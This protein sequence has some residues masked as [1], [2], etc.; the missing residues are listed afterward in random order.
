[1]SEKV[2]ERVKALLGSG[3]IKGFLGLSNT[4]GHVGPHLFSDPNDLDGMVVG[5]WRLPGDTRY[6][7]NKQLIHIA[8]RYPDDA[9]GV[10][11]RGCDDRGLKTLYTWNQLNPE[12]VVPVGVACPQELAE[13]CECLRPYPEEFV[14]GEKVEGCPFDSVARVNALDMNGRFGY[15]VKEFSRCI[16]CYGC[17]DVCPMCFCNECSLEDEDLVDTGDIPPEIPMFHLTRAVHMAGRCIDCGLCNE[18]CP[19]DIPLRTLYK[20]VSVIIH[21]EFNYRPGQEAYMKSPLNILGG[22]SE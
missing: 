4:Y 18:V 14:D 21:E 16:K 19:S 10:L 15:W 6:S 12:K 9:F 11:V 20:E 2:K 22:P 3:K 1:M 8:R 13:A 7:L 5:D 17:R